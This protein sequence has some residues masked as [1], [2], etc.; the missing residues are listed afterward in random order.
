MGIERFGRLGNKWVVCTF[1]IP[2]N[3]VGRD[4]LG[5]GTKYPADLIKYRRVLGGRR[6][7][8]SSCDDLK[9][10]YIHLSLPSKGKRRV[11]R[12]GVVYVRIARTN[13]RYNYI[14]TLLLQALILR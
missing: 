3:N 10:L 12:I 2:T 7:N 6:V 11:F 13:D 8:I 5:E 9:V 1:F 14:P 4:G